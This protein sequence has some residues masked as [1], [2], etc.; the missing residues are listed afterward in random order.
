MARQRVVLRLQRL[1]MDEIA[2]RLLTQSRLTIYD[3]SL[4]GSWESKQE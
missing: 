4:R 1:V 2:N 3:E